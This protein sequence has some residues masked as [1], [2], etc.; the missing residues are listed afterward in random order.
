LPKFRQLVRPSGSAP[1]QARFWAHSSTA[2][3]VPANGSQATRRPLPSI[4]TAIALSDS[5]S[6]RTAASADSGRRT[7]REPTIESY[8]WKI[9]RFEAIDGAARSA[10]SVA[11]ESALG[12]S[13]SRLP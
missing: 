7:V 8:C 1:T 11:A 2:S 4:E 3:I 6:C 5:G 13:V 10:S 9:H 12:A